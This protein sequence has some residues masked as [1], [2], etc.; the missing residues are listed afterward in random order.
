MIN[1]RGP[2]SAIDEYVVKENQD[3]FAKEFSEQSINCCLESRRGIC[4]SER[5][6]KELKTI[7]NAVLN[8]SS[9]AK[10]I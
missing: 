6:Y 4:E 8:V 2:I 3:K 9:G 10:R 7:L 5:H 1:M